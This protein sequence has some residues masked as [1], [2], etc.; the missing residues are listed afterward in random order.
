M[1]VSAVGLVH[2]PRRGSDGE[3]NAVSIFLL[4]I[5]ITATLTV[6]AIL[7]SLDADEARAVEEG[8]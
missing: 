1:H 7:A 6:T 3:G 5:I 4:M 8:Q 2:R